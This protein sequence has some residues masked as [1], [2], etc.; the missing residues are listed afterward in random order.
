MRRLVLLAVLLVAV[1]AVIFAA[2]YLAPRHELPAR[3]AFRQTCMGYGAQLPETSRAAAC[4]CAMTKLE[5]RGPLPERST[6][7][8][9]L[10]LFSDRAGSCFQPLFV[11]ACEAGASASELPAGMTAKALCICVIARV[12]SGR[13]LAQIV[14]MPR[15]EM[16]R[17]LATQS[18][19]CADEAAQPPAGA[20]GH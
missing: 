8:D 7:Q 14:P 11:E 2:S 18:R 16:Q 15:E 6:P 3:D 5:A 20:A 17:L 9:R 4:E 13:S 19:S 12:F 10:A 1:P